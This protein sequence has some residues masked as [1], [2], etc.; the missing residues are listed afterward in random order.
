MKMTHDGAVALVD[1]GALAFS[2]ELEKLANNDRHQRI[3]DLATVWELLDAHGCDP[4]SVDL[5]VLDGWRKTAKVKPWGGQEVELTLAPYRRGLVSDELLAEFRFR[6]LDLEYAS[7]PHYAGHVASAYCTSPFA[8]AG[9]DAF[10][11]A[12]DGA[13]F[14]YLYYVDARTR[15]V[16]DGRP[17]LFL[18]GDTYHT[19]AQAHAP[20]DLPLEWPK[21]L[22]L[23]GKIMAY[24]ALGRADDAVV[25]HL[26]TVYEEAVAAELS[27]RTHRDRDYH[28]A[29]GRRI[30]ARMAARSAVPGVPDADM[31]ASIHAF[32]GGRIV[33]A[34]VEAVTAAPRQSRNLCYAGG[35]A[36]NI[37][38]NSAIRATG[39]FDEVWIP[40]FPNDAGSALGT[41]CC[42]MLRHTGVLALEWD[43]Y[44]GPALRPSALPPGWTSQPCTPAD[45]A[46][47]L[48][49]S[50]E[51]V[52][53]LHGRAELGPRALGNRSILAPATEAR[54]RDHLNRIKRREWYRPVAPICLEDRAAAVFEPGTPDP[55]M[56]FD[57][58]V[59]PGW[60]DRVP[61]VTHL[62]GT[63]RLQTVTPGSAPH[64]AAVLEAYE[65]LSG[66]PVLCNTSANHLGKGFFPDVASAAAWGEVDRIWSE[67]E[68]HT[69][70]GVAAKFA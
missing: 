33:A 65:R 57:H 42:A 39:A 28:E 66:V 8:A 32:L 60:R 22:G 45:L 61:A 53:V 5:F 18:L 43:V 56:L 59:R 63:A 1:D 23:P 31:L 30:V 15:Q 12:W 27:G 40:P 64:V 68:L 67:G 34:L 44:R 51:P 21:T 19:L 50:G 10:V 70:P 14:P 54:M 17:L 47:E 41:A 26:G 69:A 6:A 7:Y 46:A 38:W 36:L 55:Y 13:M 58:A 11:L 37:K 62:D 4:G 29:L 2:V 3:D 52:V 25:A 16:V 24:E 48:H 35:C 20:F 9:E 49:L